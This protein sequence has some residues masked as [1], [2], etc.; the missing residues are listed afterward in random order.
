[1][2][3]EKRQ[4]RKPKQLTPAS[5]HADELSWKQLVI[6]MYRIQLMMIGGFFLLIFIFIGIIA[7]SILSHL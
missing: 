1:M 2:R 4:D 7:Y 5:E 6:K 3:L